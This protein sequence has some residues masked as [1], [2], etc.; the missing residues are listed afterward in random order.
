MTGGTDNHV[1]L[2]NLTEKNLT[3]HE[4]QIAL[5]NACICVNKNRIP[6]DKQPPLIT[7]GIRIGTAAVT[8]RGMKEAEMKLVAKWIAD[9]VDN[10]SNSR[11]IERVRKQVLELLKGFPILPDI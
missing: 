10:I 7:S 2:V 9:I 4:V 6:F 3:G 5:E 8:S 1:L 11:A